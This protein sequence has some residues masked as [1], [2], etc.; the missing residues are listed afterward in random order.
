MLCCGVLVG[1][2][3]RGC[4]HWAVQLLLVWL[5]ATYSV[6]HV[7]RC[8]RGCAGVYERSQSGVW[9]GRLGGSDMSRSRGRPVPDS[10]Q[11]G[12]AV[13]GE[14]AALALMEECHS[15]ILPVYG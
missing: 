6:V 11:V 9:L 14:Y 10:R 4:L 5:P 3:G 15:L 8:G 1:S 7:D 12:I 2:S 13:I